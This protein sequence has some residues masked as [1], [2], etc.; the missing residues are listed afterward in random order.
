MEI[1]RDTVTEVF[2]DTYIVH[3]PVPYKVT[4]RDTIY[5]DN[6]CQSG[7]LFVHEVKE[8]GDSTYYAR[9]SGINAN[10][11]EWRTYPKTVTKYITKTETIYQRPKKWGL[12]AAIEYEVWGGDSYT[13]IFG[14]LNYK[15]NRNNFFVQGGREMVTNKWYVAFGYKRD[16]IQW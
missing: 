9:I 12:L 7:Q 10:L 8:Y 5:I 13:K 1:V 4:V 11:E 16:I 6:F 3:N 2:I 15:D 14:E